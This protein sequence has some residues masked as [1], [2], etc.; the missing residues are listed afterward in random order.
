MTHDKLMILS[1]KRDDLLFQAHLL[2]QQIEAAE[3]AERREHET[4][5]RQALEI[6]VRH[7]LTVADLDRILSN[8][9][10]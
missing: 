10:F 1:R 4:R 9:D 8:K 3:K 5:A 2:N 6:L 7:N